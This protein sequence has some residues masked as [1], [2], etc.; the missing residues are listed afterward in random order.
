M[1]VGI[2]S[3]TSGY[4]F[5]GTLQTIALSRTLEKLGHEATVLDYWPTPPHDVPPWR[6]WG[7]QGKDRV[8]NIR[9]RFSQLRH[10]TR[11]NE[12]YDAFKAQEL[13]WTDRCLN[14]VSLQRVVKDFDSVVVGSDQV[15]NLRY[16]PDPNYYLAAF[17]DFT[18]VRV[19]YAACCGN[20]T[21][22]CPVWSGEALRRFDHLGV[23][24]SFTAE[25][26]SRCCGKT[27]NPV[28]VV[29]PTLLYDN[30]P[31]AKIQLP[32]K[33]IAVYLIGGDEGVDHGDIVRQLRTKYGNIPIVCL[34]PTGFAICVRKWYDDVLWYLNPYEWITAIQ[35]A[36]VVYTD[37]YHAVLFAMR[38]RVPFLATYSEEVRAPR[39]LDLKVRYKLGTTIQKASSVHISDSEPDWNAVE[40]CWHNERDQSFIFLK[41]ALPHANNNHS[42]PQ[43]NI[44]PTDLGYIFTNSP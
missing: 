18:G 28:V 41:G 33:Y 23:R 31:I 39:L 3:L 44:P 12:K 29:D 9:R 24:N 37:S 43:A 16:H 1:K 42:K 20:S 35:N 17:D 27:V 38:K 8:E 5:G 13:K 26:V 40:A 22:E 11:F 32:E 15:W 30:Y 4:N 25:W 21:Q 34:M 7:L 14:R 19:S 10:S 2:L 36:T 6:G